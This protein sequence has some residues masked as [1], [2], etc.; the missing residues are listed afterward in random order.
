M[1]Y[2]CLIKYMRGVI[3]F[4]QLKKIYRVAAIFPEHFQSFTVAVKIHIFYYLFHTKLSQLFLEAETK[5]NRHFPVNINK[6]E[7]TRAV[8]VY[9]LPAGR[10]SMSMKTS[11][12][13]PV[14]DILKG[15]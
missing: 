3:Y 12:G 13:A 4:L 7:A 10:E 6:H 1:S 2:N 11:K 5:R 8:I 15:S 9:R 14:Q